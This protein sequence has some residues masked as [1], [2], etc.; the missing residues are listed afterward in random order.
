MKNTKLL[1]AT[2]VTCLTLFIVSC[3][4][5]EPKRFLP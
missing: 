3:N 4:K 5:K 2:I 1:I